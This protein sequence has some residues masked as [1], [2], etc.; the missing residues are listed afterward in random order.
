MEIV[1][2]AA[3]PLLRALGRWQLLWEKVM[4]PLSANQISKIGLAK[5]SNDYCIIARALLQAQLQQVKH[6]YFDSIGHSSP[7]VLYDLMK[8]LSTSASFVYYSE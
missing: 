2:A 3:P 7:H 4:A 5:H 6:P 8:D 1:E